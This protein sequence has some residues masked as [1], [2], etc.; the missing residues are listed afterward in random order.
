MIIDRYILINQS[1]VPDIAARTFMLS[2]KMIINTV[3]IILE[4]FQN[5]HR[6]YSL[7]K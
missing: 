1:F 6:N 2:L 7:K 3:N 4:K 5:K